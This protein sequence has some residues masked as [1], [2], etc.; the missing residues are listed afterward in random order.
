MN[1]NRGL[2]LPLKQI[3][4]MNTVL[5]ILGA[6]GGFEGLKWI[7]SYFVNRKTN[8]R[9]EEASVD[10]IEI[11]NEKKRVDWL[12]NRITERDVKVDALYSELRTVEREKLELLQKYNQQLVE[13]EVLRITK[14]SVRGLSNSQRYH[15]RR[16]GQRESVLYSEKNGVSCNPN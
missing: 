10:S 7:I 13:L 11:N 2:R 3:K 4:K 1:N 6:L 9:K 12:E 16:S 5:T 14:C 8:A 15:G